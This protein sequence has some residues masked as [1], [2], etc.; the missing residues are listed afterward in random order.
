M[1]TITSKLYL[2]PNASI[3]QNNLSQAAEA[4]AGDFEPAITSSLWLGKTSL[5]DTALEHTALEQEDSQWE[6][7]NC[8]QQGCFSRTT[9]KWE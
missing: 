7:Q 8:R 4:M 6:N 5:L 1:L 3:T 9:A 2:S